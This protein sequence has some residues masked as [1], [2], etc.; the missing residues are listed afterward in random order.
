MPSV[1]GLTPRSESRMAFSIA[2]QLAGVV[3]LDHRHPRLRDVDGRHLGQ[4]GRRAV[5][6]D[7]DPAEH[8]RV[9]PAGA[10]GGQV[11]LDHLDRLFHLLF[12]VEERLVDH[13]LRLSRSCVRVARGVYD[14]GADG[15]PPDSLADVAVGQQVEHDDRHV[16]VHAEAERGGVGDLQALL[17]HLAVGDLGEHRGVREHPRIGVVD[18]VDGLGHQHHLGADLQRALRGGG[19]GGEVRHARRRRRRS[20]PGPFPGAARRAAGCRARRPGPS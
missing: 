12:G 1:P 18:P 8:V 10:Q 16:V 14:Q 15:G 7:D 13:S 9:R 20:P 3:G 11:V 5:V 4:R 17:Q 19:V 6:V 2:L